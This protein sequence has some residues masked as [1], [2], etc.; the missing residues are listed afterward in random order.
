MRRELLEF[1]LWRAGYRNGQKPDP[2][3]LMFLPVPVPPF[4]RCNREI[5]ERAGFLNGS[6]PSFL[7]IDL[8]LA[9]KS[10]GESHRKLGRVPPFPVPMHPRGWRSVVKRS[11]WEFFQANCP[12]LG[13]SSE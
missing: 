12:G 4:S 10:L 1:L 11:A 3:K 2:K 9:A 5:L 8:F 13:L 6:K 7:R